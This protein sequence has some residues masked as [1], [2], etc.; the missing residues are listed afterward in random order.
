MYASGRDGGSTKTRASTFLMTGF[1]WF[2][3]NY[4]RVSQGFLLFSPKL[5]LK[6]LHLIGGGTIIPWRKRKAPGWP[7]GKERRLL[8]TPLPAPAELFA[9]LPLSGEQGQQKPESSFVSRDKGLIVT[10]P[11]ILK[12]L[13]SFHNEPNTIY[14]ISDKMVLA[15]RVSFKSAVIIVFWIVKKFVF[16]IAN[17]WAPPRLWFPA[18]WIH[19]GC[20]WQS[21]GSKQCGLSSP[22]LAVRHP[23]Y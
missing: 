7:D 15:P 2:C 13:L 1:K 10:F 23:S 12:Y 17:G 3:C 4:I 21:G 9:E 19:R 22:G 8:P 16:P 6:W 20:L 14:R 18:V 11:L 5:E